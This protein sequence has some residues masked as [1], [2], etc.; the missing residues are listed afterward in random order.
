MQALV[1]VFSV[2]V[3]S[4]VV[5]SPVACSLQRALAQDC[6][7]RERINVELKPVRLGTEDKHRYALKCYRRSIAPFSILLDLAW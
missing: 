7:R 4:S 2:H 6:R 5:V 1:V 3:C